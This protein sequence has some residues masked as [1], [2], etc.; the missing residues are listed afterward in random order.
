MISKIGSFARKGFS[1]V[2]KGVAV[3][4]TALAL[5]VASAIVSNPVHAQSTGPDLS[6]V[7]DGVDGLKT[8]VLAAGATVI[9][10]GIALAAVKFGGKWV[11]RLFKSFSS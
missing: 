6:A 8:A 2:R 10:A 5:G 3:A 4:C 9:A 1:L 11:L 7:T